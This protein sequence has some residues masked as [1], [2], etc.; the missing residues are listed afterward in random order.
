MNPTINRRH[1]LTVA[2]AA[3]TCTA[4]PRITRGDLRPRSTLGYVVGEPFVEPIGMEILARGGNAESLPSLFSERLV[5][6]RALWQ[7]ARPLREG[8]LSPARFCYD[9]SPLIARCASRR[10]R[11]LPSDRASI[12]RRGL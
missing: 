7:V 9:R 11:R 12:D 2:S 5:G 3:A 4:A 10:N 8:A 6:L 1:F